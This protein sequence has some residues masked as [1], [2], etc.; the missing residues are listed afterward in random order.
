MFVQVNDVLAG[1]SPNDLPDIE[2]DEEEEEYNEGVTGGGD[3]DDEEEETSQ[4][5]GKHT[6]ISSTEG[7]H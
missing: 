3:D 1:L 4:E 6:P 5:G 2:S 7:K